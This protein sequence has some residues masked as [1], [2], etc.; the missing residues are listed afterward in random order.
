MFVATTISFNLP[1]GRSL[2]DATASING[3]MRRIGVPGSIH[4][5]FSGTAAAFQESL[6]NEPVL[7]LA[8]LYIVLGILYESY[9]HPITILST[10]PS[11]GVGAILA[12]MLFGHQFT[13][14]AL[15]G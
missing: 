6:R 8:A 13:I 2:G 5:S 3:A 12:L 1:P 11:A 14:M 4:G 9:I 7:I 10:L 15:I